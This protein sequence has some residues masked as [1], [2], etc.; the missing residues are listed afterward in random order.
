[1]TAKLLWDGSVVH[2]CI[3]RVRHPATS[4]AAASC[5]VLRRCFDA[6]A[7]MVPLKIPL[8]LSHAMLAGVGAPRLPL[9]RVCG[10]VV[11]YLCALRAPVCR[12]FNFVLMPPATTPVVRIA[13]PTNLCA[14]ACV[15]CTCLIVFRRVAPL[16]M[17][18]V[19][20]T[21]IVFAVAIVIASASELLRRSCR[22]LEK[23]AL[24]RRNDAVGGS[25]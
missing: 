10:C 18:M 5:V 1:M 23:H 20:A 8:S 14:R 22:G 17:V 24:W 21:V 11:T 3:R 9:R 12:N 2:S 7:R 19:L 25:R 16:I 13:R 4:A 15:P 6:F